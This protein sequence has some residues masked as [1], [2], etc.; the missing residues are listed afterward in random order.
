MSTLSIHQNGIHAGVKSIAYHGAEGFQADNT[1]CVSEESIRAELDTKICSGP[2]EIHYGSTIF[3]VTVEVFH[4]EEI[5]GDDIEEDDERVYAIEIHYS[6]GLP[7][8]ANALGL[9][10][11]YTRKQK[12]ALG[13]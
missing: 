8:L 13:L 4:Y 9:L 3:A 6:D 5:P 1:W 10:D 7:K 11:Y 2:A 12:A